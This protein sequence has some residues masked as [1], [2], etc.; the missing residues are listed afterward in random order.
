MSQS[1]PEPASGG[2]RAGRPLCVDLDGT[3]L[4]T[5]SLHE[6]A[7]ALAGQRPQDLLRLPLWLA[8][9][10]AHLKARLAERVV[11]DA[12]T[13]PYRDA[14][15]AA[16]RA[17][18]AE[19]RACVL[20]TA[21]DRRVAEAVAGHLGLFDE[22][23][24]S[25]GSSNLKGWRKAERLAAR[26]G[27]GGFEYLGDAAADLPV[28]QEAGAASLVAASPSLERRVAA[29]L[30]VERSLGARPSAAARAR[31]WL[32]A[33]RVHQWVKNTLVI[34]PLL[35][36]HRIAEA[37]LWERAALAFV[38]LSLAASAVYIVDDLLDLA[39]DRVH[40]GKR[41]RPFAAGELPIAAGALAAPVLLVLSFALASWT[42]PPAFLAVL[43][44][45]LV[46]SGVY[47]LWRKRV[48]IADVIVLASLYVLRVVAGGVAM[49]VTP[50]PWL[51]GACLFFFV[52]LAFLE[53]YVD[54]RRAGASSG[55]AGTGQ[56]AGAGRAA[57][58]G[59]D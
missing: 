10:R 51:L 48:A 59:R 47:S 6:L 11:L 54:V 16:L 4:T 5:D 37:A 43:G 1:G 25:D 45:Y 3:L 42:L 35:A 12:A 52:N 46:A 7:V 26:F 36:S 8:G 17:A 53:R 19:G 13:L 41:Q 56:A 44:G 55:A 2:A 27:R 58:T 57:G 22:V 23:L 28:W 50:S 21:A 31:A 20:V 30:P 9:G 34:L 32:R 14:V 38:A 39:A 15:L 29:R 49:A 24:A 40:P 18:R 33:L